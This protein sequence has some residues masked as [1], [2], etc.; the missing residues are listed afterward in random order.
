MRRG[1]TELGRL[2]G[3]TWETRKDVRGTSDS[4]R[5]ERVTFVYMPQETINRHETSV[6]QAR[7]AVNR[8]SRRGRNKGG[9]AKRKVNRKAVSMVSRLQVKL[10]RGRLESR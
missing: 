8:T 5:R 6:V 3:M 4:D 7:I 2:R 10:A 1:F 9:R